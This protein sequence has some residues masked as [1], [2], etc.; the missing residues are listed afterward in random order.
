MS[1]GPE[2]PGPARPRRASGPPVVRTSALVGVR[3]MVRGIRRPLVLIDGPSGAGKS[4]FADAVVAGW[5]GRVPTLVR[6]D[7]VYPGWNG[8]D[9]GAR[10]LARTLVSPWRRRSPSGYRRWDWAVGAPGAATDVHAGAGLVVEG[11]GAFAVAEPGTPAIRIWVDAA[12]DVRRARALERDDG[13]YDA[14]WEVWDRQWRSY[15]RRYEPGRRAS[16]RVATR[17]DAESVREG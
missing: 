12:D 11:C 5:P 9:R 8:L 16:M 2:T 4:T 7:D 13:A 17:A 10:A 1:S 14:Y 3:T 15:V 6:L